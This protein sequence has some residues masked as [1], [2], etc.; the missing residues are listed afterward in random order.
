MKSDLV[1]FLA[2]IRVLNINIH[3]HEIFCFGKKKDDEQQ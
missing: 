2:T 3:K 1:H